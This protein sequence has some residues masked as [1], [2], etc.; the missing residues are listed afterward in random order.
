MATKKVLACSH[1]RSLQLLCTA[2][3]NQ[4]RPDAR[5]EF[6]SRQRGGGKLVV[7]QA[8]PAEQRN[9]IYK[10]V[11]TSEESLLSALSGE[12]A[13]ARLGLL[14]ACRRI[15]QETS[16][17]AFSSAVF[18]VRGRCGPR[19]SQQLCS[20]AH[21]RSEHDFAQYFNWERSARKAT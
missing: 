13:S 8:L 9:D 5:S 12:R 18:V 10:R 20:Q 7:Q 21:T 15:Y 16:L 4:F 19:I 1:N 3:G 6:E 2:G 11:F 14:L 17:V